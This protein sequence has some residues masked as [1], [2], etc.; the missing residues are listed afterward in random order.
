[1]S[2]KSTSKVLRNVKRIT[3]FLAKKAAEKKQN[4]SKILTFSKPIIITILPIPPRHLSFSKPVLID[5][6]P[7]ISKHPCT[8]ATKQAYHANPLIMDLTSLQ[9]NSN[10]PTQASSTQ[11]GGL[12]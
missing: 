1:M 8:P 11:T 10:I 12:G 3:K 6:P 4:L 5:I 2:H 7:E 9:P